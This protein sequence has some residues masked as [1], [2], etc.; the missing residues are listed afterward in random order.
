MEKV[1]SDDLWEFFSSQR[2]LFLMMLGVN[3]EIRAPWKQISPTS[4]FSPLHA[5]YC[6]NWYFWIF[7]EWILL[8]WT[9]FSSESLSSHHKLTKFIKNMFPASFQAR[10][11]ASACFYPH[12]KVRFLQWTSHSPE[13]LEVA[14]RAASL[15]RHLHHH[16]C[17]QLQRCPGKQTLRATLSPHQ[18]NGLI[19]VK[20]SVARPLLTQ[21]L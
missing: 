3:P 11:D 10:W 1:R 6:V 15:Q 7:C 17:A 14:P 12:R 9:S 13:S 20:D 4:G 18:V 8:K 2:T 5:F 21:E 16:H 19:F